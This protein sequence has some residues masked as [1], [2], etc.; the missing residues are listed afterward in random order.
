MGLPVSLPKALELALAAAGRREEQYAAGTL[1]R[2]G[3]S[4]ATH[5]PQAERLEV[6]QAPELVEVLGAPVKRDEATFL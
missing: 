1:A 4:L 5:G 6:V 3:L 2:L